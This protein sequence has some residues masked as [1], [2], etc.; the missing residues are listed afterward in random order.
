MCH[1]THHLGN[2]NQNHSEIIASHLSEWLSSEREEITSVGEDV[3]KRKSLC[4]VGGSVS[5]C[6]HCGTIGVP[7][8]VKNR[9]TIGSSNSACRYLSKETTKK[10]F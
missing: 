10:F 3:E 9:A 5:W 6:S 1:S 4:T 2:A 8:K 7:Q